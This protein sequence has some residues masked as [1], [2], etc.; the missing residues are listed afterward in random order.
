MWHQQPTTWRPVSDLKQLIDDWT[1][2]KEKGL[3]MARYVSL[4]RFTSQGV[5][6]LKKSSA[7]AA[8]F[9]KAAEKAGVKVEAQLWTTGKYDGVLILKAD[10]QVAALRAIASLAAAG[11]V[12]TS[13][14]QGFDAKEFAAIAGG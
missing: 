10:N 4:L 8:A 13:T 14:L 1:K 3:V 6:N 7:R 5:R 2:R 9:R 12:T 11:N